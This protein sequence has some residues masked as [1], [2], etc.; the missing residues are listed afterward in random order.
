LHHLGTC[1]QFNSEFTNLP[2][3][4]PEPEPKPKPEPEPEA[5]PKVVK[6][7]KVVRKKA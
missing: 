6:K 4:E 7:K 1:I 2:S 5:K 3:T